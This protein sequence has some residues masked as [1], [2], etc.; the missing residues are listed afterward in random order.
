M[1]R[2]LSLA[3]LVVVLGGIP[4]QSPAALILYHADLSGPNESPPNASPG[5]GFTTVLYDTTAHTLTVHVEFKDLVLTGSGTT[6][7]HIHA[8]TNDP[9]S[10]TA[11][12]A[13][14]TP[15]FAGFPLGVRSGT[16]D[17]V[18]D[19]TSP[20]AYNP[21]FVSAQGGIAQA[22]AALAFG[23]ATGR[24]YLNIHSGTFGG[25]EIRGFLVTPEPAS[26]VML[27][28][29]VLGV[30]ALGWRARARRRA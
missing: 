17:T 30:L 5:T 11:G 10:G 1:I 12:V 20:S 3:V 2:R 15:T 18:L 24:D 27:G 16:Y 9:F 19:L 4:R 29:G 7:S 14:T 26:I 8:F 13:T 25:G 6:A 28:T 23:L 22:E 21:A